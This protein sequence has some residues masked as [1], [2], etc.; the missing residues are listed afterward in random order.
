MPQQ[1]DNAQ[2]LLRCAVPIPVRGYLDYLPVKGGNAVPVAGG[3]I[4][5]P[6]GSRQLVGV[7]TEILGFTAISPEKLKC[8]KAY[9]LAL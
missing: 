5:I 3:R 1:R 9:L 8:A 7:V 6:L 4:L 2:T